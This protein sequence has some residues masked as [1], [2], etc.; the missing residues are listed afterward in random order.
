[1]HRITTKTQL[2][3]FSDLQKHL[4]R[5]FD[6]HVSKSTI[7]K[8]RREMGWVITGPRYCQLVREKNRIDRLAFAQARL[9]DGD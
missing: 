2:F 1:M 4:R 6:L 7:K 3:L 9:A 5:Q 8:V